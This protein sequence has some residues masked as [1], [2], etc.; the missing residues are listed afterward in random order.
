[1]AWSQ[2]V[3]VAVRVV[4]ESKATVKPAVRV[5]DFVDPANVEPA[6]VTVVPVE[7]VATVVDAP[8]MTESIFDEVSMLPAFARQTLTVY[9]D[10]CSPRPYLS[11]AGV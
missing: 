4:T 7:F 1:M 10:G 9:V 5:F 8:V 2:T 6:V 3:A 11:M